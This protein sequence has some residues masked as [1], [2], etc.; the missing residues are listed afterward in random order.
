MRLVDWNALLFE[1]KRLLF[2]ESMLVEHNWIPIATRRFRNPIH[3][4]LAFAFAFAYS[5]SVASA[6]SS[7]LLTQFLTQI[8]GFV[9]DDQNGY[10]TFQAH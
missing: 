3:V 5:V 8:F 1:A 10:V 7:R 4:R 9:V 6:F 2:R